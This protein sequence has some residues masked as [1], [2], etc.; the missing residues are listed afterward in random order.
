MTETTS[1]SF[2]VPSDRAELLDKLSSATDRSRSWHLEQAL[3]Q[4]L[5]TQAWQIQHIQ[6]G[7]DDLKA[8]RVVGQ[9]AVEAWLETWGTDN[10]GDAP[11]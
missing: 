4:Y 7:L 6:K 9:D 3:A 8:G 10:E 5:D 11:V 1:L 2:R